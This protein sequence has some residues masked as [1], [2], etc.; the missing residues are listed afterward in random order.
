MYQDLSRREPENA[1]A[2]YDLGLA[3]K[4]QDRFDEAETAL[5]AAQRLDPAMPEA[6][7]TLGVVLWQTGRAEQAIVAF[8]E[9]LTRHAEFADAHYMLGT[10]L[11]QT[12]RWGWCRS[13]VPRNDSPQPA[14]GRSLQLT[15][16]IA[17][18]GP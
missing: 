11:K 6:P 15:R 8:R 14:L 3:L 2:F 18:R 5:T 1:E 9:A 16:T 17:V 13:R 10:V 12:R 4:Q 7:Y